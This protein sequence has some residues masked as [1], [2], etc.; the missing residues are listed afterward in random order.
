M[1]GSGA[2]Q[3]E[4]LMVGPNHFA[5]RRGDV[6]IDLGPDGDKDK[7][8]LNHARDFGYEAPI[9]VASFARTGRGSAD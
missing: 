7:I 1:S 5:S 9:R 6:T 2:E 3:K 4:L 8:V